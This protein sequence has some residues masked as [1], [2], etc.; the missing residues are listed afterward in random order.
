MFGT[1]AQLHRL[2]HHI[3]RAS[4]LHFAAM[5]DHSAITLTRAEALFK[6][7]AAELAL[8]HIQPESW[9]GK[10]DSIQAVQ[11]SHRLDLVYA[12]L[13]GADPTAP[14]SAS[15]SDARPDYT[16]LLGNV[17]DLG[18]GQGDL[19][20]ALALLVAALPDQFQQ[21][22]TTRTR[23]VGVDPARA[24]YGS[25]YTLQQAQDKLSE[26]LVFKDHLSFALGMTASEA[27]QLQSFDTVVMAHS[28]WY[29]PSAQVLKETFQAIRDAGVKHLLLAEWALTASHPDALP[30]LLAALLQGQSPID[31]GNIRTLVSPEQV[32]AMASQ[33]GW[34][35]ERELTFLPAEKLQDGRWEIDM[36]REAANEAAK[37]DAKDDHAVQKM[38]QSV[39]ATRYALEDACNR[40][41]KKSRSMDVWTAVLVP[42]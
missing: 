5:S 39:Q 9:R 8:F 32:K 40:I 23:I 41:G 31:E 17:M 24:D 3:S 12:W 10:L 37:L 14:V 33:A 16:L 25:P 18:C 6:I 42:A 2:I 22:E 4:R 11:S 26:S 36:A 20:G 13:T 38:Q 21:N 27:L 29:F 28:L 15:S 1:A 35:V 7:R 30:H 19:T 34:K